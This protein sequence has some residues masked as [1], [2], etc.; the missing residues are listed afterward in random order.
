VTQSPKTKLLY[1]GDEAAMDALLLKQSD[2]TDTATMVE[3]LSFSAVE[4]TQCAKS[5]LLSQVLI[6]LYSQNLFLPVVSLL[7]HFHLPC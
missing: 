5:L 2:E 4:L 7:I 3:N 1:N 6:C